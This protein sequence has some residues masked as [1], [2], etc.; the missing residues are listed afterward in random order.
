MFFNGPSFSA[1]FSSFQL[2]TSLL[3]YIFGE[4][5]SVNLLDSSSIS[6]ISS[7]SKS[8]VIF[9]LNSDR[10]PSNTATGTA[11]CR[12]HLTDLSLTKLFGNSA[13][14]FDSGPRASRRPGQ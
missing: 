10:M 12:K 7:S 6:R 2:K 11:A 3:F 5:S 8:H 13:C 14:K 1:Y 4:L 9:S